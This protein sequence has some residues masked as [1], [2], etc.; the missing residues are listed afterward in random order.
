MTKEQF[1]GSL[2]GGQNSDSPENIRE[3]GDILAD[4]ELLFHG[5]SG[6]DITRLKSILNHGILTGGSLT[7]S[8]RGN[9][10][11]SGYNKDNMVSVAESPSVNN[12]Y[13]H[14][15]YGAFVANGIGLIIDGKNSIPDNVTGGSGIPGE[16]YVVGDISI[17][18]ISGVILPSESLDMRI[19]DLPIGLNRMGSG[20]VKERVQSILRNLNIDSSSGEIEAILNELDNNEAS[21]EEYLARKN[22]Q[23]DLIMKLDL[24]LSALISKEYAKESDQEPTLRNVLRDILPD[25]LQVY[26]ED[27]EEIVL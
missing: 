16:R 18:N 23:D 7:A 14:G 3:K 6:F 19:E 12:T 2:F 25:N 13:R 21:S 1:E 17:N 22:K 24:S 4:P 15:A 26:D 11:F 5:I 8:G 20:F 10:N 27:G 9:R